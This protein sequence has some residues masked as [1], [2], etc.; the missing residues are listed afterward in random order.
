ME[1]P[2]NTFSVVDLFCG[3]GGLTHGFVKEGFNVVAGVDSD[4]SCRYAYE[5][6][7]RTQFLHQTVED[8]H[9]QDIQ[10]LFPDGHAKVLVG[11]APCQPFSPY[12]RKRTGDD[13]WRLLA[14]FADLIEAIQPDIVSMENVPLL[15]RFDEGRVFDEF[16]CRLKRIYSVTCHIVHCPDYGI[17]QKRSRLVLFASKTGN[18]ELIGKTHSPDQYRSVRD[19]IDKLPRIAAGETSV[20]D[21]MHKASRMS[22][23]NLARIMNSTP[24]GSWK[25]WDSSLVAACHKRETGATYPSVYG[26]MQW[27]E[28]SPTITTQCYGF[29]NGR[30]GHPEQHRALSLREAALLQTFPASYR[31]VEPPKPYHIKTLGRHIGNAVPVDLGRVI[32]RSILRHLESKS[33]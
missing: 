26:R 32:A 19:T 11:C 8:L 13:K 7:N 9:F 15:K 6:N 27:D 33:G 14:T 29:G 24:G 18:V 1:T 16:L 2:L 4:G 12:A 20:D 31:F 25:S 28:P 30:F 17:P 5:H 22:Q 21:P 3:V 10:S 23:L